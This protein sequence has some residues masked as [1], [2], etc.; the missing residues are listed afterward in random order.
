V[1]K[2]RG[3]D[4]FLLDSGLWLGALF[5][6]LALEV[7]HT[8]SGWLRSSEE[9]EARPDIMHSRKNH[10]TVALRSALD[11]P[12]E[13]LLA[14]TFLAQLYCY[15]AS[16]EIAQLLDAEPVGVRCAAAAALGELDGWAYRDRL[17]AMAERDPSVLVRRSCVLALAWI[18]DGR[19]EDLF[20]RSLAHGWAVRGGAVAGLAALGHVR[21]LEPIRE[22]QRRDRR[23]PRYLLMRHL[24]RHAVRSLEAQKRT[25]AAPRPS[26]PDDPEPLLAKIAAADEAV[27][28]VGDADDLESNVELAWAL[29]GKGSALGELGRLDEASASFDEVVARFDDADEREL[30][31]TLACALQNKAYWLGLA[32]QREE[33][34]VLYEAIAT[35]FSEASDPE[36]RTDVA[37]ARVNEGLTLD[38]LERDDEALAEYDNVIHSFGDDS[39]PELRGQVARALLAKAFVLGQHRARPE[40]LAAYDDL[41]ERLGESAEPNL[42]EQI[43]AAL[44]AKARELRAVRRDDEALDTLNELLA[45]FGGAD[46]PKLAQH[47]SDALYWRAN[48]L[49]KREGGRRATT[50]YDELLSRYLDA[51]DPEIRR[52]VAYGLYKKAKALSE[53]H[54]IDEA[55]AVYDELITRYKD[56]HDPWVENLVH[57]AQIARKHLEKWW[58]RLVH[59][60]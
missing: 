9:S 29:I 47:V 50:A 16:H 17:R 52:D 44:A 31:H 33:A 19:D 30:Q 43:A 22:W 38:T 40:Q 5:G 35:R 12:G 34:V 2:L 18:A 4:S 13:Q 39:E 54:H 6:E 56:D 41:L 3:H 57:D 42:R 24:Y 27:S 36:L 11:H 7:W 51:T 60:L 49:A 48:L 55:M 23:Y 37:T 58:W 26:P 59:G 28:R 32:D 46:E 8:C 25:S 1:R 10:D 21:W 15:E 45:R 20:E 53:F 14:A